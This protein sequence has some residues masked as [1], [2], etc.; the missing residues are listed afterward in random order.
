MNIVLSTTNKSPQTARDPGSYLQRAR[1]HHCCH[2]TCHKSLAKRFNSEGRR[3]LERDSSKYVADDNFKC[4]LSP[5][6]SGSWCGRTINHADGFSNYHPPI[7]F[8]PPPQESSC[9]AAPPNDGEP[10]SIIPWEIATTRGETW[11]RD[12]TFGGYSLEI[13]NELTKF[14]EVIENMFALKAIQKSCLTNIVNRICPMT[15]FGRRVYL[16]SYWIQGPF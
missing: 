4:P 8:P 1:T 9:Q 13:E 11:R 7:L 3:Y 15:K 16:L 5:P 14:L 6:P 2:S 10:Q 12:S